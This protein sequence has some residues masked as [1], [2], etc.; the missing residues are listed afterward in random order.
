[1]SRRPGADRATRSTPTVNIAPDTAS[2]VTPADSNRWFAEEVHAHDAQLKAY[3]RGS[4]PTVRDVDDVAQESYLRL[5]KVCATQPI[6]SAKALLFTVARRLA[7]DFIRRDRTVPREDIG[8]LAELSVL[9]EERDAS[10]AEGLDEK[11]D[12]LS[13]AISHLPGRCRE[14]FILYKIEGLSRR[15]TAERL[16]LSEKTVAAHTSTAM[17]RCATYLRLNGVKGLFSDDVR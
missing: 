7:V 2:T 4:F 8:H 9:M 16:G 11:V 10:F 15:E 5:W 12:L 1:V 3:L 17:K 13:E 6:R 14:T